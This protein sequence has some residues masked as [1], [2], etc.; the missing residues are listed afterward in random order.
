MAGIEYG[1]WKLWIDIIIKIVY[2]NKTMETSEMILKK[3]LS[4]KPHEKFILIEGLINSLDEPD[5]EM[6]LFGLKKQR[7]G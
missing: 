2:H 7:G 3:A 5:K 4:L 6:M 1:K